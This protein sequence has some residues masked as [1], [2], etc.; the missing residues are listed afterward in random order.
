MKIWSLIN[1]GRII[2]ILCRFF[3]AYDAK[4]PPYLQPAG[5]ILCD[6]CPY[7]V[8]LGLARRTAAPRV[9]TLRKKLEPVSV[10][11]CGKNY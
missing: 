10:H 4:G 3:R 1:L 9:A 8:P 5:V 7:S 11:N 6:E 2:T